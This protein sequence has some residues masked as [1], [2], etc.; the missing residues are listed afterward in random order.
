MFLAIYELVGDN[1]TVCYDLDGISYPA[2][3]ATEPGMQ[4]ML[5]NYNRRA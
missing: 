2:D 4:L 5:V 1:L 3:F